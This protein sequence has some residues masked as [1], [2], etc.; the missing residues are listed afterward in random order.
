MK[1]YIEDQEAW[2]EEC[3]AKQ[4]AGVRFEVKT[5]SGQWALNHKQ[6]SSILDEHVV[7]VDFT[8]E[9]NKEDYREVQEAPKVEESDVRIPEASKEILRGWQKHGL[10]FTHCKTLDSH[11]SFNA[12]LKYYAIPEQP[13]PEGLSLLDFFKMVEK[14]GLAIILIDKTIPSGEDEEHWIIEQVFWRR[15]QKHEFFIPAQP[16][17]EKLLEVPQEDSIMPKITRDMM[18]SQV[19]KF[20]RHVE[21]PKPTIPPH[22]KERALYW[23]QQAAGTNEVWQERFANDQ[24]SDVPVNKEPLWTPSCD[25]RV[26]P[27]TVTWY[28]CL[29]RNTTYST[30]WCYE[31]TDKEKLLQHV[32]RNN[33]IIIGNIESREVEV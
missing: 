29:L 26:K 22:A 9:G 15:I 23:S 20:V 17:P 19:K 8:F 2:R 33:Y 27:K 18:D 16:I 4:V 21:E 3:Q 32:E 24:Y 13:I 1:V 14:S 7:G 6:V 10:L 11:L 30:P 28:F 5:V 25:Y 31:T 12:C